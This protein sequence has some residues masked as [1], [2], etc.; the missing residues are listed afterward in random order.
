MSCCTRTDSHSGTILSWPKSQGSRLRTVVVTVSKEP[1]YMG[2]G[3]SAD[4]RRVRK[5]VSVEAHLHSP[6]TRKRFLYLVAG[7]SMVNI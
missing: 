5:V 1:Q 4:Q 3:E 6:R 2:Q 7:R